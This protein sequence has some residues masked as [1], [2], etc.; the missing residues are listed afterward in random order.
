M[1]G[2]IEALSRSC[3]NFLSAICEVC[4]GVNDLHFLRKILQDAALTGPMAVGHFRQ[5]R[6]LYL[7][8]PN[9]E[10]PV[11]K[12][13]VRIFVGSAFPWAIADRQSTPAHSS[14]L[15][16]FYGRQIQKIWEIFCFGRS[17]GKDLPSPLKIFIFLQ[18]CCKKSKSF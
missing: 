12:Q 2:E 1:G 10:T 7:R 17:F 5:K 8:N 9:I 15:R 18:H 3:V 13:A 4:C 14:V 11:P 16:W 6:K